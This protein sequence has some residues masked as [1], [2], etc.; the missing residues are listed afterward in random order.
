M[1][2]HRMLRTSVVL[3][4]SV[5]GMP[6][7]GPSCFDDLDY[8]EVDLVQWCSDHPVCEREGTACPSA[9]CDPRFVA[10]NDRTVVSVPF[11]QVDSRVDLESVYFVISRLEPAPS[12]SLYVY[13]DEV[14]VCQIPVDAD[15]VTA[16]CAVR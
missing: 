15:V 5:L 16:T 3:L 2:R 11:S 7:C 1:S 14:P 4:L 12:Y 10:E 6:A 9:G 8:H 13:A